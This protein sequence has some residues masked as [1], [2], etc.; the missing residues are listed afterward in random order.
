VTLLNIC[1]GNLPEALWQPRF[2]LYRRAR[3]VRM[4]EA[5]AAAEEPCDTANRCVLIPITSRRPEMS[6]CLRRG[7]LLRRLVTL[8]TYPA[9]RNVRMSEARASAEEACDTA[10]ICWGNLP[11]ALWQPRFPLY[12]RARDVRMSE[13][14]AAAEEACDTAQHMLGQFA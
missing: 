6:G 3:N 10:N 4:S 1:W 9:P 8:P 5:R 13:A 12:R 11:E 14:R 7:L 2:P